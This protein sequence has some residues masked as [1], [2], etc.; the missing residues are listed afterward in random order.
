MRNK[1]G[2]IVK[3]Y[4]EGDFLAGPPTGKVWCLS[5]VLNFILVLFWV[6]S[7]E[8]LILPT[9]LLKRYAILVSRT[10]MSK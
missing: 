2:A 5:T 7:A 4:Y 6:T 8:T 3:S 1:K 9:N 10:R